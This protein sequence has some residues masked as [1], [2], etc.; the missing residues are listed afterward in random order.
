MQT[1]VL[2]VL[3]LNCQSVVSKKA[4]LI[5]LVEITNP[6]II[7]ASETW[8]KPSINSSEFL[9]P[10]YTAYRKDREDGYGGVLLA[11]KITLTSHQL[12]IDSPCEIVACKFEQM[13]NPLIV[14]SVYRP[15]NSNIEYLD[16]MCKDLQ[17]ITLT[18]SSSTIW[19][20]GDLNLPDINWTVN[21]ITGHQSVA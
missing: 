3:V 20:G 2:T 1:S 6:D 5:C 11:H 19:I 4:D 21:T 10:N 17:S 9:P 14:C 8:L 12:H 16:Q 13:I 15:P 18:N 7:I